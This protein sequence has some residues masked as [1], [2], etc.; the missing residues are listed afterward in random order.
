MRGLK[1]RA[2]SLD[3]VSYL[4]AAGHRVSPYFTSPTREGGKF[5]YPGANPRSYFFDVKTGKVENRNVKGQEV[6]R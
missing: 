2:Y 3:Q 4:H 1:A 6:K 5:L